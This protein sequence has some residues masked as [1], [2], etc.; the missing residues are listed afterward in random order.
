MEGD[1][2]DE[3][4][5]R[6]GRRTGEGGEGGRR[7]WEEAREGLGACRVEGGEGIEGGRGA[8]EEARAD[9]FVEEGTQ[10]CRGG[11]HMDLQRMRAHSFT[12]EEGTWPEEMV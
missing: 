5:A 9:R 8:R 11:G 7:A 4:G 1:Q 10:I 12:P 2:E 6:N 3:F